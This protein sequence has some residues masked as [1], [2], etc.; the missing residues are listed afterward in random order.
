MRRRTVLVGVGATLVG[1]SALAASGAFSQAEAS[2]EVDI[3]VAPDSAALLRLTPGS[4]DPANFVT[5][6]GSGTVSI[7]IGPVDNGTTT[8]G[9]GVNEGGVT[10]L[11]DILRI[12]NQGESSV[13]LSQENPSGGVVLVT[14][15]NGPG[16]ITTL[17]DSN[18]VLAA[19]ESGNGDRTEVGLAIDAGY[20]TAEIPGTIGSDSTLDITIVADEV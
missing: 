2:R 1:G 9:G 20:G 19:T 15:Y 7:D 18:P 10:A 14:G 12:E 17:N 16:D 13:S 11:L 6:D 8:P 5:E 4:G 3:S